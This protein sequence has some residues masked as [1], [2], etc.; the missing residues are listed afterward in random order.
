MLGV[1]LFI[2]D[3][4]DHPKKVLHHAE[5]GLA[6]PSGNGGSTRSAVAQW[7]LGKG[8]EEPSEEA[9]TSETRLVHEPTQ[10]FRLNRQPNGKSGSL[11]VFRGTVD[12]VD[13]EAVA[14]MSLEI[15]LVVGSSIR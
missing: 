3:F 8:I 12:S 14:R 2:G 10:D 9:A 11:D 5:I 15:H 7:A 4:A 6:A 13:P 1:R